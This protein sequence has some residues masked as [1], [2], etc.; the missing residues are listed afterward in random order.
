MRF[1]G[2]GLEVTLPDATTVRLFQDALADRLDQDAVRALQ[3][4][5]A[6]PS[7]PSHLNDESVLEIPRERTWLADQ[8]STRAPVRRGA[9]A[10]SANG[11]EAA[12]SA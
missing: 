10:L 6:E 4:V 11:F 12:Q 3:I 8:Q 9:L 7:S 1:L 5:K 2:L